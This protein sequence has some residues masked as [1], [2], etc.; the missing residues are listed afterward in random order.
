MTVFGLEK[1]L[2]MCHTAWQPFYLRNT[3]LVVDALDLTGYLCNEFQFSIYGGENL[4]FAWKIRSLFLNLKS[5]EV[6][7]YFIFRG[8]HDKTDNQVLIRIKR[9]SKTLMDILNAVELCN[10]DRIPQ[11]MSIASTSVFLDVLMEFEWSY[12]KT[13]YSSFPVCTNIAALLHCPVIASTSDYLITISMKQNAVNDSVSESH[14]APAYVPLNLTCIYPSIL[15]PSSRNSDCDLE[16]KYGSAVLTHKFIHQQSDLAK[17]SNFHL[18]LF[19]TLLG[20]DTFPRLR[21]PLHL[22]ERIKVSDQ[23]YQV[24]KRWSVLIDWFSKFHPDSMK[25]LDEIVNCYPIGRHASI[26]KDL[27]VGV[28]RFICPLHESNEVMSFLLQ[29]SSSFPSKPP[30]VTTTFSLKS[31]KNFKFQ[32][33]VD[34]LKGTKTPDL[35][36]E[37]FT[38][39]WPHHLLDAFRSCR[40]NPPSCVYLS[41]GVFLPTTIE[42]PKCPF[43]VYDSSFLIRRLHYQVY[44]TLEHNLGMQNKLH[45]LNPDV[46]EYARR[47]DK[48]VIYRIP[49][50]P[51][52][53]DFNKVTTDEVITSMLGFETL[54]N[55]NLILN[56]FIALQLF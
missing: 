48:L 19:A 21:I 16:N 38:S 25:P 40:I 45:G 15:N 54:P 11:I 20:V 14:V 56:P 22:Q 31:S 35:S 13:K 7:P 8:R 37:D 3:K 49:I 53:L 24:N 5:H 52:S 27:M 34:L 30:L 47:E 2:S 50:I 41:S 9:A 44:V 42:D 18:P 1:I 10:L 55:N 33:V 4:S 29:K 36:H 23:P 26:L 6:E 32:D 12:V 51:L 43:S 17:I 28:S 39:G 46:V